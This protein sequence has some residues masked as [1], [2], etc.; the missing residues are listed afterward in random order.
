M[1]IC[2]YYVCVSL[3]IYSDLEVKLIS[4]IEKK[5]KRKTDMKLVK[6]IDEQSSIKFYRVYACTFGFRKR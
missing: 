6:N 5:L 1:C 3:Y 2:V 4:S